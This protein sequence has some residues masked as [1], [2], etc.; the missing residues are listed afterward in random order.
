MLE[1]KFAG[2]IVRMTV[3]PNA[4]VHALPPDRRPVAE[5][6]PGGDPVSVST[7][8]VRKRFRQVKSQAAGR[9]RK[10]CKSFKSKSGHR[11]GKESLQVLASK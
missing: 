4:S 3:H 2:S 6:K 8:F 5:A 11:E 9:A 10:F 7:Q 1:I